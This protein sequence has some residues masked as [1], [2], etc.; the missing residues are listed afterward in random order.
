MEIEQPFSL[1]IP[2]PVND[3]G[4]GVT[5][6]TPY[7]LITGGT[8]STG[9]LQQV[10]GLGAFGQLLFSGGAN[11]L[12]SWT[13]LL[14]WDNTNYRLGIGTGTPSDSLHIYNSSTANALIETSNASASAN[15]RFKKPAANWYIGAGPGDATNDFNIYNGDVASIFFKLDSA[16]R[17]S[18]GNGLAIDATSRMIIG[19]GSAT[20]KGLVIKGFASQ[21]ANLQEWQISDGTVYAS[22]SIDTGVG[23]RMNIH[24]S[25][26]V[27]SGYFSANEGGVVSGMNIGIY[28]NMNFRNTNPFATGTLFTNYIEGGSPIPW[29]WQL[30]SGQEWRFLGYLGDGTVRYYDIGTGLDSVIVNIGGSTRVPLT[31]KG[32]ASQSANLQEWRNSSGT[33]LANIGPAGQFQGNATFAGVGASYVNCFNGSVASG[34]E[35]IDWVRIAPT[36]FNPGGSTTFLHTHDTGGSVNYHIRASDTS[37]DLFTLNNLGDFVVTRTAAPY[38]SGY[39]G[40]FAPNFFSFYDSGCDILKIAPTGAYNTATLNFFKAIDTDSSVR[41]VMGRTG[42]LLITPSASTVGLTIKGAVSQSANLLELQNSSAVVLAKVRADGFIHSLGLGDV[43]NTGTYLTLAGASAIFTSGVTSSPGVQ[44]NGIASMTQ[45]VFVVKGGATPG[46]GGNLQ[47]WQNSSLVVQVSIGATGIINTIGAINQSL[48]GAT[49]PSGTIAIATGSPSG[50][51]PWGLRQDS[52]D[53]NTPSLI[54]LETASGVLG[55]VN[56]LYF[57]SVGTLALFGNTSRQVALA[58]NLNS[59]TAGVL[60][61]TSNRVGINNNA[62]LAFLHVLSDVAG[63]KGVIVQG[64]A[65]R[66]AALLNLQTSAG[67]SLGNV[68]GTIFNDFT[69]TSTSHTD[70]TEDDLYSYTTVANTFAINGDSVIE[71]EHVQFVGSATATRRLKKYFAGTLIFDSGSLTLSLGGD[72]ILET[73]VIRESSTVVRVSVSVV[74]TSASSIPYATYTRITG[75]TLTG[76]NILKTTGIAA[77]VGAASGDISNLLAKVIAMP[78]A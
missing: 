50:T 9:A 32:A 40:L 45:P 66:T 74:T 29:N 76:T 10:S 28:N 4:T 38:T 39:I 62:P 6:F 64:A 78:A 51:I 69:T 55:Y 7:A 63:T 54:K 19:T 26:G 52:V 60:V 14:F 8:T 22:L 37:G 42:N 68:G 57:N 72:F 59:T 65:S 11:A 46:S 30:Y 18:F 71:N 35:T 77:G 33:V 58:A 67:A 41:F 12:P 24:G 43:A 48:S 21:S 2:I 20:I 15:F 49:L 16:A 25:N 31:V 1:P 47:E 70:G 61:D 75:L 5:S 3:G 53:S 36:I 56:T 17:T 34:Y 44:I 27:V 23:G 73:I 13:S